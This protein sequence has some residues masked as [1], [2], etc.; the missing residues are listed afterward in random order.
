M[1]EGRLAQAPGKLGG[2]AEWGPWH[3]PRLLFLGGLSATRWAP[4]VP[5]R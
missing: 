1:E 2:T 3:L 4:S 5:S